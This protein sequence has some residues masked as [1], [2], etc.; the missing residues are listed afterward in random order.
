MTFA[1]IVDFTFRWKEII[2][3]VI[4]GFFSLWVALLVAADARNR[5]NRAAATLLVAVFTNFVAR[6]DALATL[7]KSQD[8]PA[9][10]HHKWL[11]EKLTQSSP[12]LSSLAEAAIARLMPFDEILAVHLE[13]FRTLQGETETHIERVTQDFRDLHEQGKPLRSLK[14]MEADAKNST[15]AFVGAAKHA[16]CATNRLVLLVLSSVPTWNRI[17]MRVNP[18]R[19]ELNCRALRSATDA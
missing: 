3:A 12:K 10:D 17:R 13:L 2:G 19:Q 18:T 6:H 5:E 14:A 11:S 4:G 7:A 16:S 15:S 1:E 9:Q 8:V